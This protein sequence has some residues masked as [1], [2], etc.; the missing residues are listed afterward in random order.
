ML[1]M[2]SEFVKRQKQDFFRDI[3]SLGSLDLYIIILLSFLIFKNYFLFRRLL[4]GLIIIYAVV[5][6]IKVFY[7]KDRPVKFPHSSF[8][9]RLDASSFPSL[10]ASRTAFLCAA[11]I[12]YVNN[13]TISVI[14]ILLAATVC[15]SRIYLKKHDFSD[16]SAGIL[17]G[18]IVYYIV[19]S[20]NFI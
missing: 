12:S 8:I 19:N 3:T 2:A 1:G 18:V 11:F 10:H 16:V 14:L 9:D 17:L 20:I 6:V 5:V 15:Y 4:I 7:F 13:A